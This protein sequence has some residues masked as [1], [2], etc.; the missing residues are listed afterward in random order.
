MCRTVG[1]PKNIPASTPAKANYF[2]IIKYQGTQERVVLQIFYS[3]TATASAADAMLRTTAAPRRS[4]D[5]SWAAL[6]VPPFLPGAEEM[7]QYGPE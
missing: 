7:V 6:V 3:N 2:Y 4:R 5:E 1:A